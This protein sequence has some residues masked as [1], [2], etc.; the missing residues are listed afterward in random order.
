VNAASV[1]QISNI[2]LASASPRRAELLTQIG[3]NFETLHVTVDE[4]PKSRETVEDYVAR[5]AMQ[6]AI[7]G[8]GVAADKKRPVLAADTAVFVDEQILGKPKGADDARRMLRLLSGKT[9]QVLTAVAVVGEGRR[10]KQAIQRSHVTM[11]DISDFEIAAYWQSGEP[12]GKA[13]SYAV[14]GMAAIFI[15]NINGSYSGIMGLPVYET[16]EL[17]GLP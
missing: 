9:H 11:R 5:L 8:L 13:G 17:L 12:E 6:K 10:P 14:Q 1:S 16:A 15:A 7:A 3:V 4:S 2:Y